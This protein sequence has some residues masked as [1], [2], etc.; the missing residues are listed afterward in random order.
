MKGFL[1]DVNLPQNI[2]IWQTPSF[3]HVIQID[4]R[5]KDSEIWNYAKANDLTILTKDSDFYSL[6]MT[7]DPPPK[8]IHFRLGNMRLRDFRRFI[9]SNWDLILENS[10]HHKLVTVFRDQIEVV[11]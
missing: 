6:M 7:S 3:E 4:R 2:V 11:E 5:M 9:A 10:N 1:V 8:V